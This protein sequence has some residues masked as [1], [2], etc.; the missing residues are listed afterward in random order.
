MN[1][2]DKHTLYQLASERVEACY[3]R[4]EQC[5]NRSF[6]RPDITLDQR[7]KI[8][9]CARLQ[10]NR[11]KLSPL[12]FAENK[13]EFLD[14]VI[15]HE[16]C[17]LLVF[18]LYGRVKPHG[19]EWKALMRNLYGLPGK[20][21]HKMDVTSVSQKT[22]PYQCNC[23]PVQLTIRR[24]NKTLKGVQYFCRRCKSELRQAT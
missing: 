15:P 21:T 17:H 10:E 14:V 9:G 8:A 23:G 3:L 22:V 1:Q 11:L 16:I 5:L 19:V 2:Q 13:Q 4:A 20:A 24:H 6:I 18:T 12:L 7:G